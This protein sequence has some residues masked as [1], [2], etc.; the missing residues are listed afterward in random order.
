M[1]IW[2]SH[3][4]TKA[5]KPTSVKAMRNIH[6][7]TLL[8]FFLQLCRKI[9][10][11]YLSDDQK[12]FWWRGREGGAEHFVVRIEMDSSSVKEMN[13]YISS[14]IKYYWLLEPAVPFGP[15]SHGNEIWRRTSCW[16]PLHIRIG[17][18]ASNLMPD[19]NLWFITSA[20][21]TELYNILKK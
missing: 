18:H 1:R 19:E 20:S 4:F 7:C 3:Y 5:L 2:N 16:L 12:R 15:I 17:T 13:L 11:W 10:P 6:F 9:F 8:N 21:P 14:I